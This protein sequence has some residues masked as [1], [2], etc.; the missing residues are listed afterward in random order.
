MAIF[1]NDN[2]IFF[3]DDSNYVTFTSDDKG[4]N[5]IYLNSISIDDH[6]RDN[7]DPET[8]IRV[9][10]MP[11]CNRYKQCKGCK[12]DVINKLM[13]AWYPKKWWDWCMPEVE[14]DFILS[15]K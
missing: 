8:I 2:I 6:N 4:L 3:K 11:W 9:R 10:L 12:N 1:S 7:D 15:R 14:N 5:I 13:P